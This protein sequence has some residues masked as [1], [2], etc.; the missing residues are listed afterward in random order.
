MVV[1]ILAQNYISKQDVQKVE[2]SDDTLKNF[3]KALQGTK[4]VDASLKSRKE[5]SDEVI[6]AYKD[7]WAII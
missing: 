1:L 4:E 7:Y 6:A 5:E 3:S 2:V